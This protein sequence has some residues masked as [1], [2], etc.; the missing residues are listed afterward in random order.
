MANFNSRENQNRKL[1]FNGVVRAP[2]VVG[3]AG[4]APLQSSCQAS[5]PF[6]AF[7]VWACVQK[8]CCVDS[9]YCSSLVLSTL[10]RCFVFELRCF[11]QAR[12]ICVLSALR[13]CLSI[14]RQVMASP[15][16]SDEKIEWD[17]DEFRNGRSKKKPGWARTKIEAAFWVILSIVAISACDLKTVLLYD[18][19]VH[20]WALNVSYWCICIN[21]GILLY[22]N[23]Y[24]LPLNFVSCARDL[25]QLI[26][27]ASFPRHS[28]LL[29][30]Q[31]S[32][33]ALRH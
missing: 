13:E 33:I 32:Q 28:F 20:R 4:T 23:M 18:D 8:S 15:H 27:F 2:A 6:V 26:A 14:G 17:A 31:V 29:R 11:A 10:I 12:K 5:L 30:P 1:V 7:A 16:R 25:R 21:G 3:T 19:R 22:L 24:V 9:L